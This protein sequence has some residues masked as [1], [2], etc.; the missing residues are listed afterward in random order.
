MKGVNKVIIL[1][2]CGN[3]PEIKV[4]AD[5]GTVANVSVAT[6]ESWKDKQTG[7]KKERT[8]WH[9]VVF[10]NKLAEIVRDYVKKGSKIYVEGSNR[11]RKYEKDGQTH[12]TTEVY[13]DQM[14]MLDS[15]LD[16]G[17][18]PARQNNTMAMLNNAADDFQSED[19]PF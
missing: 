4:F 1:G 17:A 3:D 18:A 6:S 10:R 9:R 2:N 19:I 7:E 15:R 14:Q 5:G 8:E 12:Y 11:T 16:S 13:A